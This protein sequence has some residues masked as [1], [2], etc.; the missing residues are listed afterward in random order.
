MANS[1]KLLST[2]KA[3]C[4]SDATDSVILGKE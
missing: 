1:G 2:L 3:H 4:P